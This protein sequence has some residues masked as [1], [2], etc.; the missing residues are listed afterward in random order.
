MK[1]IQLKNPS[2]IDE[3]PLQIVELGIPEP[4]EGQILIEVSASGVCHTDLH[5]V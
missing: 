2:P 1:A 5:E 4:G 3:R